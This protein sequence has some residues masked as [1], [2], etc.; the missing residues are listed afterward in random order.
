MGAFMRE[1]G[2][3]TYDE[4]W[5]WSVERP[6]GLLGRDLGSLRRRRARRRPCSRSR[7]MPGAQW[8]PG[9]Q[10]QLRRA[11]VRAARPTTRSRSIAGG[12]DREDVEWTW[13]ELREQ[14]RRIAAGPAARSAS[15]AATASSPTCRTSPRPSR[16]SWRRASL[17]AVWSSCSPDFGARSVI[18]RFAQ[19]EPKVL[20]AVDATATTAASSTAREALDGDRRRDAA[21]GSTVGARRGPLGR[22]D[23]APTSRS[24]SSA[25]RSTTRCGCSTR[26]GTTGLPKAIVQSQGGI[27]LEHLKI[28]HLHVDAQAGDRLFWFTTTGWMMWNFIVSG[29]LTEA[30]DRCSTTARPGTRTWTRCGTSRR[31][32]G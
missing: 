28:L 29:L 4:L 22:A 21:A 23:R 20:L 12:E 10:R 30:T 32:R 13:G 9:T 18:D 26:R 19:I 17:G 14:V 16:R 3:E 6:R 24:S 31:A 8:F 1:R 7:E 11:R 2:F 5:R 27:L 15:S 25:C